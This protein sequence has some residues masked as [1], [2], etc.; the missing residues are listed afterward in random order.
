MKANVVC[1]GANKVFGK[2]VAHIGY[3]KFEY[4]MLFRH[5]CLRKY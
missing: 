3:S 5:I 2:Y 4:T 1:E